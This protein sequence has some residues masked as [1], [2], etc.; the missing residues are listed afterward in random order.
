[1]LKD[2]PPIRS[3]P[4][5]TRKRNLVV[6]LLAGLLSATQAASAPPAAPYLALFPDFSPELVPILP[7]DIATQLNA[8]LERDGKFALVQRLF[9]LYA[10]QMFIAVNWPVQPDGTAAH[11]FTA[12]GPPRWS[13]WTTTDA[14]FRESAGA[15]KPCRNPEATSAV[16]STRGSDGSGRALRLISSVRDL[17]VRSLAS[18]YDPA[19]GPLIDQHGNFVYYES[20]LDPNETAFICAN[21]LY[22]AAGETAYMARHHR[23][24]FPAG[25]EDIAWSGSF[26]IKLAWKVLD[27]QRGDQPARFFTMPAT[28][29]DLDRAGRP[30]ERR[31]LV[32]LV[33]MHI[34]HKSVTA[35]QRIWATFEQVDNLAVDPVAHPGLRPSFFDP[36]C[37]LCLPNQPPRPNAHGGYDRTPVQVMR[38]VPIAPDTA[39]LDREARAVLARLGSVWRYYR[40][41]G[42]Q[43]P[44]V[45]SASPAG[46]HADRTEAILDHSGG[47]PT[48]PFLANVTME[49][50]FQAGIRRACTI[51][52][53]P[54]DGACAGSSPAFDAGIG[55]IGSGA[56][57]M[58]FGGSGCMACHADAGAITRRDP[59]S[60]RPV[61]GPPLS[62]DFSWFL[63]Q[64][65]AT[66]GPAPP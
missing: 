21:R 54:A 31:V 45:P 26:S 8:S 35:P 60:G 41:I 56:A 62:G 66:R 3:R 9:D 13:G 24:D 10:W 61:I 28:I 29:L 5:G 33:G 36:D 1:M 14:L 22:D 32:G 55:A 16:S 7:G 52:G 25:E 57:A 53:A 34:V 15:P 38:T 51:A 6:I 20:L 42:T 11:G 59:A 58:V 39:H 30:V 18:L 37:A 50:Y 17:D 48:P 49:T 4:A 46:P 65:I 27:V 43:W 2:V 64:N 47:D 63:T 44:T 23:V 19:D 12:P 40:L